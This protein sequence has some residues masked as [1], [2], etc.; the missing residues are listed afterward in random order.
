MGITLAGILSYLPA[1]LPL[2]LVVLF[3]LL[4]ELLAA[5]DDVQMPVLIR[6]VV[7]IYTG[8]QSIESNC[9]IRPQKQGRDYPLKP[10]HGGV[11]IDCKRAVKTFLYDT[12]M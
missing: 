11:S 3:P 4:L 9:S 1:P 8:S 10:S 12:D 2:P 5:A 6:T 7:N